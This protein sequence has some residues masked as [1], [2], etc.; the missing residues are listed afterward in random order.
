MTYLLDTNICIYWLKGDKSIEE[1][2]LEHGLESLSISF[3][4]LSELYFG[5]YKSQKV[6][7]N[8]LNVERL[9]STLTVLESN[10]NV[11]E[12]FGRLKTSLFQR[13]NPIDDADIFIAACALVHDKILITN[14]EK[15]FRMMQDLNIDNWLKR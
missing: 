9:K 15:H 5:A 14:N 2:A 8:L 10:S 4:T 7:Y 12:T 6:N 11:C 13:G 1:K 3:M